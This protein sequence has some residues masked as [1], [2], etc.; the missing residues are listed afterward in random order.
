M[1]TNQL[2]AYL[3]S[4]GLRLADDTEAGWVYTYKNEY[5]EQATVWVTDL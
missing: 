3:T 5:H 2:V 4:R 1:N